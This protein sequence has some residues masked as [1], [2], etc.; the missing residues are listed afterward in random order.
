M[1]F[2]L[3]QKWE[4]FWCLSPSRFEFE[5]FQVSPFSTKNS[6]IW[7]RLGS[8][9]WKIELQKLVGNLVDKIRKLHMNRTVIQKFLAVLSNRKFYAI[10]A[11]PNFTENSLWGAPVYLCHFYRT[12]VGVSCF[13]CRRLSS[14]FDWWETERVGRGRANDLNYKEAAIFMQRSEI[15]S[16]FM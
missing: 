8:E 15:H 3:L 4:V 7:G 9:I 12:T 6:L 13:T 14:L 11:S 1:H 16:T 10:F 2:N 5:K